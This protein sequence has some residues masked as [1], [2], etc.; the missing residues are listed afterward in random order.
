MAE[1]AAS[2]EKGCVA[3]GAGD[4]R[5]RSCLGHTCVCALCLAHARHRHCA[6]T[7]TPHVAVSVSVSVPRISVIEVPRRGALAGVRR[8]GN[9]H[10]NKHQRKCIKIERQF[11]MDRKRTGRHPVAAGYSLRCLFNS[12]YVFFAVCT[13]SRCMRGCIIAVLRNFDGS[14]VQLKCRHRTA[15]V[16]FQKGLKC[17]KNMQRIAVVPV[18]DDMR[19]VL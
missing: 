7:R 3:A 13:A 1:A 4:G 18:A 2:G 16:A 17:V 14:L 9:Y 12:L 6:L 11:H 10:F 19:L 15:Y 8:A 5:G